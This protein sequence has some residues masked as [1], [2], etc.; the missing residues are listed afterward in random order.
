MSLERS[1][2]ISPWGTP[3]GSFRTIAQPFLHVGSLLHLAREAFELSHFT[4]LIQTAP[5]Q[6]VPFSWSKCPSPR[7]IVHLQ[8]LA[9]NNNGRAGPLIR[10][11]AISNLEQPPPVSHFRLKNLGQS[12]IHFVMNPSYQHSKRFNQMNGQIFHVCV[13]VCY[14]WYKKTQESG[15]NAHQVCKDNTIC[16]YIDVLQHSGCVENLSFSTFMFFICL[17]VKDFPALFKKNNNI[18]QIKEQMFSQLCICSNYLLNCQGTEGGGGVRQHLNT[19]EFSYSV[20]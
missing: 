1:C 6:A 3:E 2:S 13:C 18:V 10:D 19:S 12:A 20:V 14:C 16:S 4:P 11:G 15:R 8:Y 17:H 7:S 5:I 9:E